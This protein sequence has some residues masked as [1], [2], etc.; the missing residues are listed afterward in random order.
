MFMSKTLGNEPAYPII[1]EWDDP[2][3]Q[4]RSEVQ[5]DGMTIRQRFVMAAMQGLLSGSTRG[6]SWGEFDSCV[7]RYAEGAV[8]FADACLKAEAETRG[9]DK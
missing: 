5:F 4:Q 2:D 8:A 1:K 9:D 7:E 3:M 6:V